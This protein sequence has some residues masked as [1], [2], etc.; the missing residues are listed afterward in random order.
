[1]NTTLGRARTIALATLALAAFIAAPATLAADVTD[2]GYVDQGA[3]ANVPSFRSANAQLQQYD[4]GLRKE[5]AREAR[6]ARSNDAQQKLAAQFQAKLA[7]RQRQLFSPLFGKAQV[8][9]ASIASSKNLSV[10]V[11]KRIVVFGGQDIT[12]NVTDLLGSF[13]DPVPPVS[14]PP[15]SKVGYVDQMQIDG[16]PK[17]KAAQAEFKKFTGE[18]QKKFED[19]LKSVKSDA[20]RDA[21]YKEYQKTLDDRS[22]QTLKPLADQTRDAIGATAKKR[23]LVLVIDRGN[24]VYGG[25]DITTDV[26]ASLK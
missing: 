15:P 1:M 22:A 10:V 25:T 20:A 5:F 9:I 7:D 24:L 18:Q 16:L 23:G 17:L 19:R 13:G 21:I 11:D 4:A 14:T 6:S 26:V 3:L 8:A 12:R 2:I